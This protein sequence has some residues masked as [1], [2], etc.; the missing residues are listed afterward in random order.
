MTSPNAEMPAGD[1]I[2]VMRAEYLDQFNE[3]DLEVHANGREKWETRAR[4]TSGYMVNRGLLEH[5]QRGVWK[6]TDAGKAA[7]LAGALPP[8]TAD[9]GP[10]YGEIPGYLAG[11]IFKDRQTAYAAGIH[12]TT[13]AG[14]AGPDTGVYSICM[15]S[16]YAHDKFDGDL[17]T[18]TGAGGTD[19][20]TKRHISDQTLTKWNLGLVRNHENG[21]PIR[22]LARQSVITGNARD[23]NYVYLGLYD[24][25]SWG[26][27]ETEGFKILVYQLQAVS[28]SRMPD[29]EPF[30]SLA[31]GSLIPPGR[32]VVTVHRI[33]RDP[34]VKLSLK[35]LYD[36]QCQICETRLFTAAGPYSEGA[37]IRPLGAP[38]HGPDSLANMLCLC[39]NC[40]TMFDGRALWVDDQGAIHNTAGPCGT[41][42][43]KP[44][45]SLD[46]SH[47]TYHRELCGVPSS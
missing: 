36:D 31:A 25:I 3:T 1:V 19:R 29:P 14:I 23:S 16:G 35:K 9:H 45:H 2:S 6:L 39:P 5:P 33:I 38:H 32:T 4:S 11:A 20:N 41:L 13:Q 42:R 47:L 22:V 12:P 15:S 43:V 24:V 7:A 18:Y 46:F 10:R 44:G 26:W 34:K 8:R 40:H 21:Q 27:D 28:G 30:I 37:H 17:I